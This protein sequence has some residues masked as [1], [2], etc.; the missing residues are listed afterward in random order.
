[1]YVYVYTL[2]MCIYIH[3]HICNTRYTFLFFLLWNLIITFKEVLKKKLTRRA[4]ENLTKREKKKTWDWKLRSLVNVNIFKYPYVKILIDKNGPLADF[5][6]LIIIINDSI[7]TESVHKYTY[8]RSIYNPKRSVWEGESV[9]QIFCQIPVGALPKLVK[10]SL[11]RTDPQIDCN[12][13]S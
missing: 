9:Y 6:F 13:N 1:M 5:V 7:Y 3:L 12:S 8:T 2:Y 11:H 4:I 10:V